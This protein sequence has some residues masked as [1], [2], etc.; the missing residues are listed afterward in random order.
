MKLNWL[1]R[2]KNK[3][4]WLALIPAFLVLVQ[5]ILTIFGITIDVGEIGNKL[6][7]I[8]NTVFVLLSILGIAI[9]PTTKGISDS[10]Q[11]M[12]YTKPKS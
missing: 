8:V 3:N 1:V 4:F 11:A 6:I 12:T 9:D 5:E 2:V 10:E 7:D